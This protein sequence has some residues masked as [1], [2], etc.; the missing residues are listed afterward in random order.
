MIYAYWDSQRHIR[1]V[2]L[3]K[4]YAKKQQLHKTKQWLPLELDVSVEKN[5]EGIVLCAWL[6][7]SVHRFN[8]SKGRWK[9]GKRKIVAGQGECSFKSTSDQR[10]CCVCSHLSPRVVGCKC[11]TWR[12]KSTQQISSVNI[13]K[14]QF[15]CVILGKRFQVLSAMCLWGQRPKRM[16][17]IK[18]ALSR[19][20]RFCRRTNGRHSLTHLFC[21]D[22][23]AER[24]DLACTR[25]IHLA[26]RALQNHQRNDIL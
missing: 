4:R 13:R 3:R 20:I 11:A 19:I 1:K 22:Q 21:H 6:Q 26:L 18:A 12:S 14:L 17:A 7:Y 5:V 8:S 10:W 2:T 25:C 23:L 16:L 15:P 24:I 9:L